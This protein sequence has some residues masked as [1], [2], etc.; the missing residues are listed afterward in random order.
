MECDKKCVMA[1]LLNFAID[2]YKAYFHSDPCVAAFAPGRVN[3]IGEHTDYNDGFVLPIA[4]P[5]GT[6]IVG[7]KNDSKKVHLLSK[8]SFIG[9]EVEVEFDLPESGKIEKEKIKWVNYIKGV[10]AFFKGGV[11][12]GF[13]AAIV[14]S[15]PVGGGLSSS[16]A[17]E[18][19]TYYFLEALTGQYN[20][21]LKDKALRCQKAEHLYADMPCGI[22]DQFISIMGESGKALL[23]DCRTLEATKVPFQTVDEV[24]LITNSNVKHELS[25]SEYP[26]RRKQCEEAAEILGAKSLRDVDFATLENNKSQLPSV[27]YKRARHVVTEIARTTEAAQALKVND[28]VTFG[29]LMVESHNSLRDDYEVSCPELNQLVDIANVCVGVYGSRMTGGGFG[30]CTVTLVKQSSLDLVIKNIKNKY[31]GHPSFYIASPSSGAA[32]I[33][34][35]L[36][37]VLNKIAD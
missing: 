8:N 4:L 18:V 2:S 34:S 3:L 25:G 15:V 17:L 14:T 27:T 19:S 20:K 37:E 10:I 6:I 24:V 35:V 28:F 36:E 23:L 21:D 12:D 31:D 22:M 33:T 32:D 7:A 5:M 30:G 29:K 13:N 1:K 11:K 9:E 16:A 26:I